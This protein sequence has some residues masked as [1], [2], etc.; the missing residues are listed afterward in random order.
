M[1]TKAHQHHIDWGGGMKR[2]AIYNAVCIR[3]SACTVSVV[4]C[5][6]SMCSFVCLCVWNYALRHSSEKLQC[7][8]KFCFLFKT[9]FSFL[10]RIHLKS[11]YI[12]WNF[13][14]FFL[15]FLLEYLTLLQMLPVPFCWDPRNFYAIRLRI[16]FSFDRLTND[17]R[18]S[19]AAFRW[20]KITTSN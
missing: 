17:I 8:I 12:C 11:K 13:L 20:K 9:L 18:Y 7:G 3:L 14:N 15:R 16:S 4:V 1:Y 5:G 6:T 19:F 2:N 10:L